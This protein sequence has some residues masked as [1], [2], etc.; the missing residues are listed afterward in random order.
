MSVTIE[1]IN[2]VFL[3]RISEL[4]LA[5]PRTRGN[6]RP[7]PWTNFRPWEVIFRSRVSRSFVAKAAAT[8]PAAIVFQTISDLKRVYGEHGAWPCSGSSATS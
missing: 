6:A 8:G 1:A 2:R 4:I 7:W 3:K 5:R